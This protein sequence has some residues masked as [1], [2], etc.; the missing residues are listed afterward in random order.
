MLMFVSDNIKNIPISDEM[1]HLNALQLLEDEEYTCGGE[2]QSC[3][4]CDSNNFEYHFLKPSEVKD[5]ILR[6][7]ISYSYKEI[8]ELD[9][10]LKA[11][12]EKQ[13][14]IKELS[15][16]EH[17]MLV[18]CKECG[19]ILQIGNFIMFDKM[20]ISIV[21]F[22]KW[23]LLKVYGESDYLLDFRGKFKWKICPD[24]GGRL[25]ETLA[26]DGKHCRVCEDCN[27]EIK[28]FVNVKELAKYV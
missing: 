1:K 11:E 4:H 7:N 20:P 9:S 5:F 17:L 28:E 16:G 10:L 25:Y 21:A 8:Y 3:Y 24:C 14:Q 18:I 23:G 6:A 22:E 13:N 19:T 27:Q 15:K 2:I 26:P 12:W